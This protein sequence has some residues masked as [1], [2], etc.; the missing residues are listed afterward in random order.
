MRGLSVETKTKLKSGQ[1]LLHENITKIY[2]KMN[3]KKV[4]A[5]NIGAKKIVN[6]LEPEDF[7]EKMQES[8]C[9]LTVKDYKTTFQTKHHND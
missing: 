2:L 7:V 5:I 8:E 9:Y 4:R 3:N 6:D 1:K